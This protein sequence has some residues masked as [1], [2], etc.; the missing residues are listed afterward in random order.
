MKP[1]ETDVKLVQDLAEVHTD[2]ERRFGAVDVALAGIQEQLKFIRWIGVFFAGLLV[3]EDFGA[4]RV[5]WDAATISGDVKQQGKVQEEVR[6]KVEQHGRLIDEQR[7]D[8]K[9]QGRRM[10]RV[11]QRLDAMDGKLDTL[12]TRS[13]PKPPG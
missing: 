11:E 2:L 10:D 7:T 6:G 4:G 9:E 1:T 13:A 8:L 3:A 12:L 5:V